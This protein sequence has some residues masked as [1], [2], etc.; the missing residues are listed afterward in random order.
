MNETGEF[1]FRSLPPTSLIRVHAWCDGYVSQLPDPSTVPAYV[2]VLER[3]DLPLFISLTDESILHT[4]PME[5]SA[6]CEIHVTNAMGKPLEGIR[7]DFCPNIMVGLNASSRFGVATAYEMEAPEKTAS[8]PEHLQALRKRFT[9]QVT[10]RSDAV[11][12]SYGASTDGKGICRI[13]N[14]PGYG[15]EHVEIENDKW[16][17]K[18]FERPP[19]RGNVKANLKPGEVTKLEIVLVPK[20]A[21]TPQMLKAPAPSRGQ[22]ILTRLKQLVGM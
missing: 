17:I 14:L 11:E 21:L 15:P 19:Y 16:T 10:P 20:V 3:K 4:L 6:Q 2:R 8:V 12:S 13:P 1:E 7:V 22:V 9:R 18:G 5:P